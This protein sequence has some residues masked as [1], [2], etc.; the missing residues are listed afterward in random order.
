[1]R[2]EFKERL[3]IKYGR[4][5]RVPFHATQR[6]LSNVLEGIEAGI[7]WHREF[8]PGNNPDSC[9]HLSI[10]V[11]SLVVLSHAIPARG[12]PTCSF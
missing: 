1:M 2:R 7:K 4:D 12:W 11:V 8:V 9:F 5:D 6:S 3:T 10:S